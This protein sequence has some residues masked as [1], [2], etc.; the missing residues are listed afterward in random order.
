MNETHRV[1]RPESDA[2][3]R[4]HL[5]R[6]EAARRGIYRENQQERPGFEDETYGMRTSEKDARVLG[7]EAKVRQRAYRE[8]Y[9]WGS[10]G[11]RRIWAYEAAPYHATWCAGWRAGRVL[12][13]KA[14]PATKTNEDSGA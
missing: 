2:A 4:Q 1:V 12:W 9:E 13:M 11:K 8:G 5:S 7:G 10:A 6:A 14:L 3:P